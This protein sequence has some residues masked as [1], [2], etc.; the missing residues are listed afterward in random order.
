[1]WVLLP[2]LRAEYVLWVQLHVICSICR[3]TSFRSQRILCMLVTRVDYRQCTPYRDVEE[4]SIVIYHAPTVMLV[5]SVHS[6]GV[7]LNFCG[8]FFYTVIFHLKPPPLLAVLVGSHQQDNCFCGFQRALIPLRTFKQYYSGTPEGFHGQ[9][10]SF[11]KAQR[12]SPGICIS[13]STNESRP[14]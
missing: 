6:V 11:P 10:E 14:Y 13:T 8:T 3:A 1:L 9:F 4:Y 12:R 5:T 7:S 2:L